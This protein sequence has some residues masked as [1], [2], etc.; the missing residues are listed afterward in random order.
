MDKTTERQAD[1]VEGQV[2]RINPHARVVRTSLADVALATLAQSDGA[3]RKPSTAEEAVADNI[4]DS[5]SGFRS[6]TVRILYPIDLEPLEDLLYR[7]RVSIV[8]M[9]GFVRTIAQRGLQQVQW[10]PGALDVAPYR[11]RRRI[12]PYIVVIG[13]RV[14][15]NRFFERL[16]ACIPAP[17]RKRS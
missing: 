9:K 12:D 10:V 2:R 1:F 16:D 5:T 4:P 13:R 15:W 14:P 7:H 3:G 8:R 17:K 6:V 11:G